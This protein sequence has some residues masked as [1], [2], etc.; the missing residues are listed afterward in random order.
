MVVGLFVCFN[1]GIM[2]RVNYDFFNLCKA[3]LFNKFVAPRM[4]HSSYKEFRIAMNLCGLSYQ[5]TKYTVG[6]A[7]P[8]SK[9]G[10]NNGC[11]LFAQFESDNQRLGAHVVKCEEL[12]FYFRE[13]P[14]CDCEYK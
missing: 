9:G 8:A 13:G 4:H 6:H 11:N 3:R 10:S 1:S 14:L 2:H 7:I 5:K 12:S